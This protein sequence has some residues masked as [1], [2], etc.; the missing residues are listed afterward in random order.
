M[1]KHGK[2]EGNEQL[3]PSAALWRV[4]RGFSLGWDFRIGRSGVD[5]GDAES[6]DW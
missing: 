1:V 5:A 3:G 6:S 2:I 4:R